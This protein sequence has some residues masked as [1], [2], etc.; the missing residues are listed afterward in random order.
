[1]VYYNGNLYN[2]CLA[3][4]KRIGVG[5][6]FFDSFGSYLGGTSKLFGYSCAGGDFYFNSGGVFPVDP[7]TPAEWLSAYLD[8]NIIG[9]NDITYVLIRFNYG[10][11]GTPYSAKYLLYIDSSGTRYLLNDDFSEYSNVVGLPNC[12]SDD[13]LVLNSTPTN[14]CNNGQ[15]DIP[16]F[17]GI[18]WDW[19]CSSGQVSEVCRAY[20]STSNPINGSCGEWDGQDFDVWPDTSDLCDISASLIFPSMLETINS[21]TWTCSGFNGGISAYCSADKT[22]PS[23][24]PELPAGSIDDCSSLGIPEV[25]FCNISNTIKSIFLPSADKITELNETINK[26]SGRFPFSY[27]NSS[28]SIISD[29]SNNISEEDSLSLSIMGSESNTLYFEDIPFIHYIKIFTTILMSFLFLFWLIR[30]IK[31]IF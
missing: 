8:D 2:L 11:Y 13:G 15:A 28:M 4:D 21:Y 10:L 23:V 24:F 6:Y 25:W 7:Y 16:V 31:D 5:W 19:S 9:Y 3:S 14:L 26:I 17:D 29:I 18:K 1:N 22:T 12:G 20:S 30:F 27:I